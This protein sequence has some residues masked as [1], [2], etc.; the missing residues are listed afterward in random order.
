MFLTVRQHTCFSYHW[1]ASI[2]PPP[3]NLVWPSR[4]INSSGESAWIESTDELCTWPKRCIFL[5]YDA[6]RGRRDEEDWKCP[7]VAST[8][9][10]WERTSLLK[11]MALRFPN[12]HRP[13]ENSWTQFDFM[14]LMPSFNKSYLS[15]P[16]ISLLSTPNSQRSC[17]LW[18][19]NVGYA[20]FSNLWPGS[21][22]SIL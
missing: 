2:I 10:P 11:S 15:N 14:H 22:S 19:G 3:Y 16:L 20:L 6:D 4:I 7:P 18:A 12:R 13:Y 9:S 21:L 5:W 1:K 8:M 17:H